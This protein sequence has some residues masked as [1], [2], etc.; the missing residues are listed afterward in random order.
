MPTRTGQS[1]WITG[2]AARRRSLELR[3]EHDAI[4]VGVGTVLA[5]D[6]LLT[7]RLG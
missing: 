4:V 5:D 2:E 6:P 3:E 7:R 1:K